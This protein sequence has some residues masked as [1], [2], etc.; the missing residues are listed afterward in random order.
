MFIK[1]LDNFKVFKHMVLGTVKKQVQ[2]DND[3]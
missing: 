2:M 1:I 3:T